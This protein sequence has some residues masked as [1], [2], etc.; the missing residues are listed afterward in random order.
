MIFVSRVA[1][2]LVQTGGIQIAKQAA[3]HV[4]MAQSGVAGEVKRRGGDVDG[5]VGGVDRNR[6]NV[7]DIGRAAN[8]NARFAGC[9][10]DSQYDDSVVC[11]PGCPGAKTAVPILSLG[12]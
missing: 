10:P 7:G 5:D 12:T 3:E 8:G 2:H 4:R 6:P 9:W 1:H 11:T